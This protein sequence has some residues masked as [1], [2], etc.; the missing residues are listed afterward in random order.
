[1][2]GT[3]LRPAIPP[4]NENA[5][6]ALNPKSVKAKAAPTT[7]EVAKDRAILMTLKLLVWSLLGNGSSRARRGNKTHTINS[8]N[9]EV[10]VE[11]VL[12]T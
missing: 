8:P 6:K 3:E 11:L 10:V 7:V 2:K 1:M 4:D 9:S 12:Q 5:I